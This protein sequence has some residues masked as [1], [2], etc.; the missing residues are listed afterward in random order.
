M[1]LAKVFNDMTV[2]TGKISFD[3]SRTNLL[4]ATIHWDQDFRRISQAPSL[5][6][7]SNIVELGASI[8]AVMHVARI[9]KHS[10]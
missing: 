4:K 6:S 1:N 3:L 5:I 8:E 7:I 10:L 2:A 9:R